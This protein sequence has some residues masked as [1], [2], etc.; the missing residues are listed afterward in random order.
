MDS[1]GKVKYSYLQDPNTWM[2]IGESLKV[3]GAETVYFERR[4][5]RDEVIATAKGKRFSQEIKGDGPPAACGR[6]AMMLRYHLGFGKERMAFR[7]K[8]R[9]IMK[10]KI[11]G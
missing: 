2:P 5:D 8:Q 10:R 9:N 1:F 4:L 6:L 7:T 11:H 3:S